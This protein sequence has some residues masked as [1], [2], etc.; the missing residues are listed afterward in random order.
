MK[1]AFFR[2]NGGPEVVEYGDFPEPKVGPSDVL[3][4]VRAAALN[5]LD[6]FVRKGLP[7]GKLPMPHISGCEGAGDVVRT[8][9][10]A[11]GFKEGDA[12]LITPA[13][14]CNQCEFCLNHQPSM[15][16]NYGILGVRRNGCFAEYVTAP[17][18]AL[19]PLPRGL[20]YEQ[21]ATI[22]LVFLTAWHMLIA[23]AALRAGEDVLIQA[24]G[25][26]VG[27]AGI[28]VAKLLGARVF[29][30]ASTQAKLDHARELGA[31]ILINYSE[32]NFAEEI[33][34]ITAKRGVDVVF[35]HTGGANFEKSIACLARNGRLV[36]CGATSGPEAQIDL[37]QIF[38][39][40]ISIIGSYMGSKRD[41]Q[42]VL[43]FVNEGKL[44]PVID[45]VF[46]LSELRAAEEK[47][48]DRN[49]FGKIVVVP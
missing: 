37:R 43:R 33:R 8:G 26:G 10:C 48:Q 34:S 42:E 7:S 40:Q 6:L 9:A 12:V 19:Y 18:E 30:T 27:I 46:P 13:W 45:S 11:S 3:V 16:L 1:A 20:S 5:H 17:A 35:E 38:G 24:G 4:R 23:R 21:A 22:P 31:D 14:S 39:R 41:L 47:M 36:M 25:S 32:K 29:C 49:V 28:Q 2:Q 15:C 44:K